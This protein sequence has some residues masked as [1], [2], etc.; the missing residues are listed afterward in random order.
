MVWAYFFNTMQ[1]QLRISLTE[2][3]NKKARTN[4]K[5]EPFYAR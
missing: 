2:V 5:F 4:D 1:S 3:K